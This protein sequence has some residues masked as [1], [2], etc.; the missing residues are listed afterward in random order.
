MRPS[1]CL[2]RVGML[3]VSS[4]AI[5]YAGIMPEPIPVQVSFRND[6]FLL[7]STP[8]DAQ[9][10]APVMTRAAACISHAVDPATGKTYEAEWPFDCAP[11]QVHHTFRLEK[12]EFLLGE[13]ILVEYLLSI[14]GAGEYSEGLGGNYR[15]RG[16]DDNFLFLLR[17]DDGT[18]VRDVH[19]WAGGAGGGP[20]GAL[21][22]KEDQPASLWSAV[23]RWCAI[24]EPGHYSLYCIYRAPRG[25]LQFG[26]REAV[27]AQ[28][29]ETVLRAHE[30][31]ERGFL[32]KAGTKE[33]SDEFVIE[34]SP[35]WLDGDSSPLLDGMPPEIKALMSDFTIPA[36]NERVR[37][38]AEFEIRGH[39]KNATAFAQFPIVIKP[40]TP[41]ERKTM[42]EDWVR[43]AET[44]DAQGS[45][46]NTKSKAILE[47]ICFAQQSDFLQTV[48]GWMKTNPD[49]RIA[50]SGQL[51]LAFNPDK[52]AAAILLG[53][54]NEKGGTRYAV[55]PSKNPRVMPNLIEL[56]TYDD[57]T[58]AGRALQLLRQYSGC[59]FFA[60]PDGQA[61]EP[62]SESQ[63]KEAQVLWRVWWSR[64]AA[65]FK[66]KSMRGIWGYIDTG[67]KFVIPPQYTRAWRFVDGSARVSL[68]DDAFS[69]SV[70]QFDIDRNGNRLARPSS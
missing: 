15:S 62:L 68:D 22:A 14:E 67:G 19:P 53:L 36:L 48:R 8:D 12:H 64:N 35:K 66:A 2:I 30:I 5:A 69:G 34:R 41:D 52:E 23:Q 4:W 46:N 13:P 45:P 56:L 55:H 38:Y 16:R 59:Y 17:R 39:M 47:A 40:G 42:V 11:E 31:D 49:I 70:D 7:P 58:V 50:S 57:G 54:D 33:K 25:S 18:W 37:Q 60:G 21:S 27:L 63:M 9:S 6:W 51:G 28:V 1:S 61:L 24:Q 29:P 44:T 65:T 3:A 20:A 43:R 32:H 26:V 10:E